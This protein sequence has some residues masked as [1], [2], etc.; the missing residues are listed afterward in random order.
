[1]KL[2]KSNW[3]RILILLAL[4]IAETVWL[5][6]FHR[7]PIDNTMVFLW[8]AGLLFGA[9][10]LWNS[11]LGKRDIDDR[12]LVTFMCGVAA[13]IDFMKGERLSALGFG[14]VFLFGVIRVLR[15]LLRQSPHR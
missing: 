14:G 1:M 11:W 9:Q 5:R 6:R 10:L 8:L 13:F 2:S 15:T 12:V 7:H 3:T 4:A